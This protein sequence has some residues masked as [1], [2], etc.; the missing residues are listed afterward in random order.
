GLSSVIPPTGYGA[1][2]RKKNSAMADKAFVFESVSA[3]SHKKAPISAFFRPQA[4]LFVIMHLC[5]GGKKHIAT[6]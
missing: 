1:V 6:C 3:I 4:A 5:F 2:D